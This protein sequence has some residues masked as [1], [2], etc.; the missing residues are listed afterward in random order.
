MHYVYALPSLHPYVDTI[1]INRRKKLVLLTIYWYWTS[2]YLKT[3]SI[4]SLEWTIQ[5]VQ[6]AEIVGAIKIR[7]CTIFHRHCSCYIRNIL[8]CV[9][10]KEKIIDIYK[11]FLNKKIMA[12]QRFSWN[13]DPCYDPGHY[14][15][16]VSELPIIELKHWHMC[17]CIGGNSKQHKINNIFCWSLYISS[18]IATVTVYTS[19]DTT[20]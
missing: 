17:W 7:N 3:W 12:T 13:N 2:V 14:T 10:E 11:V 5:Y 16:K 9:V 4:S 19:W 6:L 1:I 20:T 15:W 8:F 18:T